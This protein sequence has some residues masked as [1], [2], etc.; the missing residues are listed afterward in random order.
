MKRNLIFLSI[1]IIFTA[2]FG[3]WSPNPALNLKVTNATNEEVIPKIAY[4]P[5]GDV[6]VSWFSMENQNYNV[7]AQKFSF[8]G[9]A[10]FPLDGILVSNNTQMSW[11]TDWDMKV[12][13]E[14]NCILSFLDIRTGNQD[15]YVYKISPT[16]Q[17]LWGNNGIAVSNDAVEDYTPV[18]AVTDQNNVIVAW[19][20]DVDLKVQKINADGTLATAQPLIMHEENYRFTW[21]QI[22]P[23]TNDSFIMKYAKDSGPFYAVVRLVYAQKYDSSVNPVWTA[24]TVITDQGGISSWTQIFSSDTDADGGFSICWYE[25]RDFDQMRNVYV[26]HVNA[27]GSI[28]F[29]PNG[30]QPTV[31]ATTQHFYPVTAYDSVNNKTYVVWSETDGSQN[32]RGLRVQAIDQQ[33]QKLFGDEGLNL[34]PL[35]GLSPMPIKA[36]IVNGDLIAFFSSS[37]NGSAVDSELRAVRINAAG[38][39][40]WESDFVSLKNIA[41]ASV[42]EEVADFQSNQ[43]LI[44]WEDDRS[45]TNNLYIQNINANGTLGVQQNPTGI[46]GNITLNGGSGLVQ[47]VVITVGTNTVS[48]NLDGS[49]FIELAPGSYSLTA[50]LDGYHDS[51]MVNIT[52]DAGQITSVNITLNYITANDNNNNP[53]KIRLSN[54]PNPFNPVTNISFSI[55]KTENL[56]LS[57]Y[58][59]KGQKV[60]TVFSGIKNAGTHSF[61]WNG[62]DSDSN[63][64]ASGVYYVRLKTDTETLMHKMILIK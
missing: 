28:A 34:I 45:G 15:I 49:Y 47:N 58:N 32:L 18:L 35:G 9:V 12:D 62:K 31:S 30:I 39:F 16:G 1:L 3:Q 29:A 23:Q 63:N 25:D 14:N 53:V 22:F 26:Q 42:H 19:M 43:A 21:P 55:S 56:E 41:S 60:N 61:V 33:G 51:T 17:M 4:C 37:L 40:V 36:D 57:V 50:H 59:L 2:L 24:P 48:P 46:A 44:I 7:R 8:D 64:V 13:S 20:T 10:Q 54:Y 11:L 6:W 27:D 5:N 38:D 52:V